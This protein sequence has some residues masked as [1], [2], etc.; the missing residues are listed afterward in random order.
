M[1]DGRK[2]VEQFLNPNDIL[3]RMSKSDIFSLC[4]G[5]GDDGL[6]FRAPGDDSFANKECE[7]GYGVMMDL[8]SPIRV[9]VANYS[10][11]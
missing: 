10:C 5:K 3:R 2:F 4:A 1:K 11:V 8:R 9:R 6:L 7:T